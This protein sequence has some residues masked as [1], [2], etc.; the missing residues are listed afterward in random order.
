MA[1]SS[2]AL[3]RRRAIAIAI[4]AVLVAGLVFVLTLVIGSDSAD[5]AKD[6]TES[7]AAQA[8]PTPKPLKELPRGGRT[9]LPD[10]RVVAYYGA[11]QDDALGALG[12][13]SPA[14]AVKKLNAQ[15]KGYARKTRPVM[16]ALELIA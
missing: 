12:I 5:P 8:T 14:S 6:P 7:S 13:G 4:A 1:S 9:I 2:A 3:R 16:P 10:Y 11:P 15:A